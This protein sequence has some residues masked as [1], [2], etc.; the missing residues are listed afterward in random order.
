[1]AL[2]ER[3]KYK[4]IVSDFHLGRGTHFPD[5][6]RNYLED[7]FYDRQFCEFLEYY[8]SGKYKGTDVELIINGDFFNHMQVDPDEHDPCYVNEKVA[9]AR[10]GAIMDGHEE[11]FRGLK[12]FAAVPHH[13]VTIIIGNHDYGLFFPAVRRLV[14][15][16]LGPS[17]RVYPR[18]RYIVDGICIEHGNLYRLDNWMDYDRPLVMSEK[19]E[20]IVNLPWGALFVVHYLNKVRRQRQYVT[21]VYPFKH[22]IIWGLMHD[23]LF[24]F[25]ALVNMTWYFLK[26]LFRIG[27]SRRFRSAQTMHVVRNFSFPA[28]LSRMAKKILDQHPECQLV[29]LGH[30][31]T[32]MQLQFE[33]G[34]EY[35]NTGIWNEMI[36]LDIGTMGRSLRLTF[37]EVSYDKKNFPYSQLKE[38]KGKY[39]EV[40]EVVSI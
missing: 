34:R 27:E 25:R 9:L 1:M 36:S 26:D 10:T 37:A 7:F 13:R 19:G 2:F 40:E 12:E 5:G 14:E 16:R 21:K 3:E 39:R 22:Y 35:I 4:L 20:E 15:E 33:D 24:A 29:V 17:A 32:C 28:K 18:S 6:R 11:L 30:G 8:R 31:H 38:W 23:T